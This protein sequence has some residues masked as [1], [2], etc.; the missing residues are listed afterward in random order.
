M[1]PN[2]PT[3]DDEDAALIEPETGEE[4]VTISLLKQH[5]Y[6]PRVVYFETCTPGI[7]PRTYKM[8]AG[9][10]AHERERQRAARRT[11][12]AYQ[13]PAGERRF[14]VR[15]VSEKLG[16]SGVVD[17]VVLTPE[18][19]IVVDYKLASWIG[20]NHLVQ[21]GAYGLMVEEAFQLPVR[22]GYIYLLKLRRFESVPIDEPLRNSVMETLRNIQRIRLYEYMPPPVDQPNKCASCEFRRFCNDI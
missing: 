4:Q 1:F 10:D 7:R 14:D 21:I 15:L 20:E 19:A 5:T 13:L 12:T 9:Q 11:L 16:L 22:R 8:Q 3:N 2:L 17:E 18:E 6:C